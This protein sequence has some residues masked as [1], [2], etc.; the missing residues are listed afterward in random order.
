M[1][2]VQGDQ[3]TLKSD[4]SG[5]DEY[6]FHKV[7]NRSNDPVNVQVLVDG[8]QLNT[9]VDTGAALSIISKKT[10]KVVFPNENL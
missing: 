4:S 5:S 10:R 6:A 9:E 1:N 8:K 7:G 2:R 3:G